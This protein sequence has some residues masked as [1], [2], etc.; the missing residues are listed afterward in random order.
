[1]KRDSIQEYHRPTDLVEALRLLR[2][3]TPITLPLGGGTWV[4]ADGPRDLGAVV[5]LAGLGLDGIT[6]EGGVWRVGAAATAQAV[7]DSG[8]GRELRGGALSEAARAMAGRSLRNRASVAGEIVVADGISPLVT[9]LLAYDAELTLVS[10]KEDAPES[11]RIAL[12]SFLPY[13]ANL[14]SG[15]A[16]ITEIRLPVPSPDTRAV[17]ERVARTPRDYPIVC[18]CVSMAVKDGIAGNPRIAVG[19][20]APVPVRLDATEFGL[21]KKRI[22]QHLAA[23]IEDGVRGLSPTGDWLGGAEY[24]LAM[25]R[26]LIQRAV[27]RCAA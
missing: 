24:R 25:A 3:A 13:R 12:R 1:M 21:E 17:F 15:G 11:K 6:L 7:V 9:A 14:L 20:V 4:S 18:V 27:L 5:D 2:R 10:L 26:E 8:A 22:E 23:A 19:G 16:L